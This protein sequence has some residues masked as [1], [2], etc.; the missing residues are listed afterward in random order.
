[1]DLDSIRLEIAARRKAAGLS[2]ADL[3]ERAHVALPTLKA[4]E[5]GRLAELGFARI[6]RILAALG[7]QLELRE[8]SR[9]RPTLESLRRE[10]G[11]D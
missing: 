3:A 11:D 2:Q 1:M 8:A 7:L 4:L 6:V 5:Q 9:S 10:T